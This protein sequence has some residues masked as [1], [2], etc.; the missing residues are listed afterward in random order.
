VSLATT[1]EGLTL[2]IRDN[3]RGRA[4]GEKSELGHGLVGIRERTLMLGGRM[5]IA[6]APGEGFSISIRIPL[7]AQ[8]SAGEQK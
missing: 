5:E 6:S 8:E 7:D 1:D 3:G 4:L 2:D